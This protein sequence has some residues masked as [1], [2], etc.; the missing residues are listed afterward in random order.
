[1]PIFSELSLSGCPSLCLQQSDSRSVYLL[2]ICGQFDRYVT[3]DD[4]TIGNSLPFQRNPLRIPFEVHGEAAW[5]A[6]FRASCVIDD[7]YFRWRYNCKIIQIFRR[8]EWSRPFVGWISSSYHSQSKCRFT[9]EKSRS[10]GSRCWYEWPNTVFDF[11]HGCDRGWSWYGSNLPHQRCNFNF[12]AKF[13]LKMYNLSWTAPTVTSW[14][15]K[16]E[17]KTGENRACP[18]I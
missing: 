5:G 17:Q 10:D 6:D 8:R 7:W 4:D 11:G 13:E 14:D 9:R 2:L 12:R 1:M 15:S 16:S 3:K 18:Q